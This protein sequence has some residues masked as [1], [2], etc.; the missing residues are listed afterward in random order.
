[1]GCCGNA[2]LFQGI[3]CFLHD[4]RRGG[5]FIFSRWL[6]PSNSLG[7]VRLGG[8]GFNLLRERTGMGLHLVSSSWRMAR[9]GPIQPKQHSVLRLP[10]AG[11]LATPAMSSEPRTQWP[12]KGL[13]R[14]GSASDSRSEGWEFESL[15]PH[16]ASSSGSR[17]STSGE[18][19]KNSGAMAQR[20]RV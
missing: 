12:S 5:I 18:A 20:Q 8:S 7:P 10:T 3:T 17:P 2:N 1:M 9:K 16:C 13:W 14:N 6:L 19:K 15:W 4:S 11:R